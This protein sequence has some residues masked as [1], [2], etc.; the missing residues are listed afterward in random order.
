MDKNLSI[1]L[2]KIAGNAGDKGDE[3]KF[4]GIK[5]NRI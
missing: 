3:N 1:S 2:T 4:S 5:D